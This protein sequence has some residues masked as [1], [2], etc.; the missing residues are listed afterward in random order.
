[1][2]KHAL[3]R[4]TAA[5]I[6]TSTA[7]CA[8]HGGRTDVAQCSRSSADRDSLCR[9][10]MGRCDNAT[11][12]LEAIQIGG[13]ERVKR[14]PAQR[15]QERPHGGVTSGLSSGRRCESSQRR[16]L[17]EGAFLYVAQETGRRGL[18]AAPARWVRMADKCMRRL[19][20]YLGVLR[21][22]R[23][24]RTRINRITRMRPSPPLG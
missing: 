5:D 13:I 8:A 23:P 24:S 10:R 7:P 20:V 21:Y 22:I 4:T 14:N 15:R 9:P 12:V 3:P 18:E 1:M 19:L 2:C 6:E 11:L 16:L 17:T